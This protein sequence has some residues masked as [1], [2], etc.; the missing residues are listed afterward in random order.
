MTSQQLTALRT[1]IVTDATLRAYGSDGND[2]AIVAA[3]N[4][5]TV[6]VYRSATN[7]QLI[8]WLVGNGRSTKLRTAAADGTNGAKSIAQ[9]A[10]YVIES[11]MP[12]VDCDAEWWGMVDYLVTASVL[13]SQDKTDLQ[14]RIAETISPA[15][16][17]YGRLITA[18]DVGLALAGDR[19]DGKIAPLPES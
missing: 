8:R 2:S 10:L 5:P 9:S 11:G 12:S 15:E 7:K 14:T 3:L 16:R 18:A 13:T 4:T 6:T 19:P 1:A 17:D